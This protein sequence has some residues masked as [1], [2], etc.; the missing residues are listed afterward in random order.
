LTSG[1]REILSSFGWFAT[2]TNG[3]EQLKSSE[4]HRKSHYSMKY[5]H[6]IFKP[7]EITT[8]ED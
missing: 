6:G 8:E 4:C 2:Q 5:E 1:I 3:L 7:G